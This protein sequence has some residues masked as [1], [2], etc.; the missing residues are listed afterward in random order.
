[1]K[2]KN[3]KL[4]KRSKIITQQCNILEKSKIIGIKSIFIKHPKTFRTLLKAIRQAENISQ[5]RGA[6]KSSGDLLY[7]A[8]TKK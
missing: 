4:A 1:M 2:N 5:V 8:T 3:Q 7:T 6:D